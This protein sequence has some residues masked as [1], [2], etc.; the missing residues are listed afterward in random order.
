M[1]LEAILYFVLGF[2]CASL[3]ALMISPLIWNRAVVLTKH[4]IESSVPLTLNEIQAEKDQ[5]RAEFAM[6]TRKLEINLE[7]LREKLAGQSIEINQ[8]R[9]EVNKLDHENKAYSKSLD[10]A[11]DEKN[12]LVVQ[13]TER[14]ADFERVKGEFENLNS[15]NLITTSEVQEL[16]DRLADKEELVNSQRIE[17]AAKNTKIDALTDAIKRND[18]N[19]GENFLSDEV[20]KL[21]KIVS[22]QRARNVKLE[23]K[24]T[25]NA[26]K[27]DSVSE[28]V[29]DQDVK[30]AV[31]VLKDNLKLKSEKIEI[32]EKERDAL[33]AE[34]KALGSVAKDEWANERKNSAILRERLNDMAAKITVL[35]QEIEGDNSPI[36]EIIAREPA[37][38]QNGNTKSSGSLAKRIRALQETATAS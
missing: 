13:V 35:T 11:R 27:F 12:A 1:F 16:R 37:S 31:D 17:I 32:I 18:G 8:R 34:V 3:L 20:D 10:I 23:T 25:A 30:K 7:Q 15:S 2:L 28:K 5:L 26:L 21:N 9:D 4:K 22:E 38:K 14:S 29:T 36:S 33:I 19:G 24:L 6:S